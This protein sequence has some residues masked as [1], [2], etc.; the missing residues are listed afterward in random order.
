MHMSSS[1]SCVVLVYLNMS[2][3]TLRVKFVRMDTKEKTRHI[4]IT[5]VTL[6]KPRRSCAAVV[7]GGWMKVDD[8]TQQTSWV[9]SFC[10]SIPTSMCSTEKNAQVHNEST[11]GRNRNYTPSQLS[12]VRAQCVDKDRILTI[13][14]QQVREE[15]HAYALLRGGHG[16]RWQAI[17]FF[18]ENRAGVVEL[19]LVWEHSSLIV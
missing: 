18:A 3:V 15:T 1:G 7:R 2:G 4:G 11:R 19:L 17:R 12:I 8:D 9:P 16:Q 6:C 5:V 10:L 14:I 13:L